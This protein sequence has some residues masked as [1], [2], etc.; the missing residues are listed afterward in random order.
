MIYKRCPH[1]GSNRDRCKH[2]WYGSF[3]HEGQ[4][5][6][7]VSLAKWTGR[8]VST[9]SDA[10]KAYDTLKQEVREGRFN[11]RGCSLIETITTSTTTLATLITSYTK[12]YVNAKQQRT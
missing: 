9:K 4:N 3:Q 11:P 6:V 1:R 7:R 2:E 5:R 8:T 10:I 12:D